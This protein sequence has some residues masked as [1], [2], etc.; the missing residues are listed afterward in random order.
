M[1]HLVNQILDDWITTQYSDEMIH[2]IERDY[3]IK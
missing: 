2:D 1:N 3:H